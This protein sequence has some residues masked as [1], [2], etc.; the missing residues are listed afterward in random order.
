MKARAGPAQA[1][2]EQATDRRRSRRFFGL[3]N[4]FLSGSVIGFEKKTQSLK[5]GQGFP[6]P[7]ASAAHGLTQLGYQLLPGIRK[8]GGL[9]ESP[10]WGRSFG[11]GGGKM[12]DSSLLSS[13]LPS[14]CLV[15]RPPR[16]SF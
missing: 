11:P 1:T 5:R 13:F 3:D 15:F 14:C 7:T 9:K 6:W 2:A 12:H 16:L 8:S 4:V 10:K